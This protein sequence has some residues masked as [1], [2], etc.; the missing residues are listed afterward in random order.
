LVALAGPAAA[1]TAGGVDGVAAGL[2]HPLGGLDHL[3]AMIAV[4]LWAAQLGQRALWAVPGAFVVVMAVGG[5]L[6]A[7][8]VALPHVEPA[9]AASVLALGL[10]VA[11]AVRLPAAAGAAIAGLF[12]LFHG[13]AHGT[14]LP[15]ATSALLF[16]VG[17][18]AATALLHGIGLAV[19]L[20]LRDEA[21][22]M[23]LRAAGAGTAAAGRMLFVV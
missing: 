17:F 13:H 15:A 9:L 14:E 16:G 3:L 22:R 21:G 18:V 7:A 12:A 23:L 6:G 10:L 5:A 20:R 11:F 8:G 19:G 2:V 4:G 1:H